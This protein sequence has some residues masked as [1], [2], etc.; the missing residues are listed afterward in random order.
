MRLSISV[1]NPSKP[2]HRLDNGVVFHAECNSE[3]TRA[4]KAAAGNYQDKNSSWECRTNA[5]SSEIGALGKSTKCAGRCDKIIST[6]PQAVTQQVPFT[7]V[8]G[9]IH[10]HPLHFRHHPL[11]QRRGIDKPD[12]T[13]G[14]G[15]GVHR[16]VLYA[17]SGLTTVKPMRSPGMEMSLE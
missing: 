11:H 16:S 13:V 15:H 17:A 3:M 12:D 10:T 8:Q 1:H 2:R 5:T 4:H 9:H 7:L 6:F 14:Q